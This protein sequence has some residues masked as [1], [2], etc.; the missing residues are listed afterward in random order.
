M[1]LFTVTTAL[2][3]MVGA[4]K[5]ERQ[6]KSLGAD[7][8]I[9]PI[10][11][12]KGSIRAIRI[13]P[14]GG[15]NIWINTAS[16]SIY[17]LNVSD[18]K[19]TYVKNT[20]R[21]YTDPFFNGQF[22]RDDMDTNIYWVFDHQFGVVKYD[23]AKNIVTSFPNSKFGFQSIGKILPYKDQ[24]WVGTTGGL[25]VFTKQNGETHPIWSV[26]NIWIND[27]GI[28][29]PNKLIINH[30]IEYNI[31]NGTV[32]SFSFLD[33]F[34]SGDLLVSGDYI[35]GC[36]MYTRPYKAI[37]YNYKKK[38]LVFQ[39]TNFPFYFGKNTVVDNHRIINLYDKTILYDYVNDTVEKK[40]DNYQSFDNMINDREVIW[41]YNP[42]V[43]ALYNKKESFLR[44]YN[45]N[46]GTIQTVLDYFDYLVIAVNAD[47][48]SQLIFIRKDYIYR[49]LSPL[50][51]D[52]F[53]VEGLQNRMQELGSE[54]NPFE[55]MVKYSLLKKDI[56]NCPVKSPTLGNITN[57]LLPVLTA[58]FKGIDSIH[59]KELENALQTDSAGKYK[60]I[61]YYALTVYH[62]K[63]LNPKEALHY[64]SL[65][66]SGFPNNEF[67]PLVNS[68]DIKLVK[69]AV[70]KIDS[71]HN[72]TMEEDECLFNL[73]QI[74]GDLSSNSFNAVEVGCD[75]TIAFGYFQKLINTY[76]NSPFAD[77]AEYI[78]L[79]Y[80][81]E[82]SHEG[83]SNG[84]N[85]EAIKRY[86][87]LIHKYPNSELVPKI[88]LT[89]AS[90]YSWAG[91][92]MSDYKKYC[93]LAKEVAKQIIAKYPG[94]SYAKKAVELIDQ[95][96]GE[97][98][99]LHV[100]VSKPNYTLDE[101]VYVTFILKNV[102]EKPKKR[103][104]YKDKKIP[105]FL[106]DIEVP[107]IDRNL[108]PT[109]YVKFITNTNSYS[110][111]KV[112]TTIAP[113]MEYSETWDIRKN[114]FH[115]HGDYGGE[116]FG[117]YTFVTPFVYT[118]VASTN[119]YLGVLRDGMRLSE[120]I[121][122]TIE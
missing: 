72:V 120:S 64:Y 109:D 100:T 75:M 96:D 26:S 20:Y 11:E 2:S 32:N 115:E 9:I 19:M 111:E 92:P 25:Y 99:E 119:F 16:D 34:R 40:I 4:T 90:L 102:G 97:L 37:V 45:G 62:L 81:E 39:K 1:L 94:S 116:V 63:H 86:T 113:G 104:I 43:L 118:I 18:F 46:V 122:V 69:E 30:K 83:G 27:I 21:K 3:T 112:D 54:T 101:P 55:A 85:I 114:A 80:D 56:A 82:M 73:G 57:E 28:S 52:R 79:A 60:P 10:H 91:D 13:S 107:N 41:V 51:D 22:A 47:N 66:Q 14:F 88:M 61:I 38:E 33:D 5:K 29:A 78:M 76:P 121:K 93:T 42:Y 105:N 67:S 35:F 68:Y 77:N 23:L 70:H 71:I 89:I 87:E 49:N 24:L 7:T 95:V 53:I 8:I 50:A 108:T 117:S 48:S 59:A 106:L 17:E 103:A 110:T 65:L 98:W 74:F 31:E 36:T 84:Y 15:R 58:N 12:S 6:P 44:K